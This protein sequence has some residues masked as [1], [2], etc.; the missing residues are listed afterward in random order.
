[1][2][3][4]DQWLTAGTCSLTFG[5]N[6]MIIARN[7]AGKVLKSVP[8]KVRE[9]PEYK[10]LKGLQEVLKQHEQMCHD[11]VQEW[12]LEDE[13]IPAAVVQGLWEDELWRKHLQNLVVSY[14]PEV[15]LVQDCTEDALLLVD[16]DGEPITVPVMDSTA[17]GIVHP[18]VLDEVDQWR[19]FA[20]EL[21]VQQGVDQ[22]FRDTHV[23]PVETAEQ[24]KA[25]QAYADS[26]YERGWF[27]LSRGRRV[28]SAPSWMRSVWMCWRIVGR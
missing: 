26:T 20:S 11:T 14:G 4:D 16:L 24:H 27:M 12:L 2:T 1:M 19:E 3:D 9:L 5:E 28:G 13:L 7:S 23:K 8:D 21:G 22:L 10:Q 25:V 6:H 18:A 15:G 17:V